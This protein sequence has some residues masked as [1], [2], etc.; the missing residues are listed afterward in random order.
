MALKSPTP[1]HSFWGTFATAA[2][3]PNVAAAAIQ[4]PALETGDRA[5]VLATSQLYGCITPTLGA[6]VWTVIG[7]VAGGGGP[8]TGTFSFV[9]PTVVGDAVYKN[10]VAGEV[11]P[12]DNTSIATAPAIGIVITVPVPGTAI[13]AFVGEVAVAGLVTGVMYWLGTAGGLVAVGPTAPP[14]TVGQILGIAKDPGTL[15]LDPKVHTII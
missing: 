15:I 11:A 5:W 6:A 3:L 7:P 8:V 2:D 13:V 9:L 14:G 4:D 1:A 10:G 12:A